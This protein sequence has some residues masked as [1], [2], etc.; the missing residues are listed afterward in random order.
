MRQI[1]IS[2]ASQFVCAANTYKVIVNGSPL[3]NIPVGRTIVA[4]VSTDVATVEIICTTI[5]I[6]KKLRMKLH[7]GANPAV[8]FS[9]QWPGDIFA[10]V[11]DAQI[12]EKSN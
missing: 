3:G 6:N 9:V 11:Q 4:T 10:S 12:L 7:L 5:M 2:R 8:S 1:T